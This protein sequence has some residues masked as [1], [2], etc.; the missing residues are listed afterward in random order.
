MDDTQALSNLKRFTA[1]E[2]AQ[3]D[4]KEGRPALFAYKGKVYDVTGSK[5]WRNGV[6]IKAHQAGTELTSAMGAAPHDEH[7]VLDR[8]Q[9]V[10]IL[11]E[12]EAA[13]GMRVPPPLFELI[14]SKH[15]HPISVHFPIA[16]GLM[17]ALLTAA[18]LVTPS[19]EY[20][21]WFEKATFF[22]LIVSGLSSLPAIGTGLLSWYYNYSSVWTPIYRAKTYLSIAL[23]VMTIAVFALYL[24]VPGAR[25]QGTL[26][27]WVYS[28]IVIALGPVVVSLG[29]Y[30]GKITF[31]S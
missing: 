8:F 5:L 4:G 10:G 29:F 14:L 11:I 24:S 16:L 17:A 21:L 23:C 30:G 20:R 22:N 27:Y 19:P 28:L 9:P 7:V 26:W 3:G 18:A 25:E 12:E 15:P 1:A 13:L 2:L 31:P 6:H